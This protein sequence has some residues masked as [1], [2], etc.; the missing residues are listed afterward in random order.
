MIILYALTMFVSAL[1][2][3]MVQPM[4]AMMV[5]PLLGGS[6]A[7]WNTT[8]V[9]Y[10]VLLLVGYLYAHTTRRWLSP[11]AQL[12][13]HGVL[14]ILPLIV[15]PIGIPAGWIP[16]AATTPIPWLLALMSVA[17]G[18]PFLILSA[19]SPLLQAWFST[20][21]HRSATDPYF[22]SVASNGGS[23]LAL[24]AYPFLL[25]PR[26]SLAAQSR[27]WTA[28]YLG[29][30]ALLLACIVAVWR[31]GRQVVEV[32]HAAVP[33]RKPA[34][35]VEPLS[36]YRRCHWVLLAF[37]P[38]SLMLSVTTHLST[39][40]APIPLLWVVPLALYLLT[41]ILAFARRPLPPPWLTRRIFPYAILLLVVAFYVPATNAVKPLLVLHL[42]VYF[43]IAM[44]CH[45]ILAEDRPPAHYLTE[46]Y[47]WL[48]VGGA[49]GGIFNSLV[50]PVLFHSVAE[51]PIVVVLACALLWQ[52]GRDD[53]PRQ[54]WLDLLLPAALGGAMGVLVFVVQAQ[55][56]RTNWLVMSAVVGIPPVICFAFSRRALRFALGIGV[57]FFTY[58]QLLANPHGQVLFTERSFFGISQV[59]HNV[60]GQYHGLMH[61]RI[62]H[63]VQ[64]LDP[65]RRD[66]PLSYYSAA[67]P[68]GQFFAA[69]TDG[70]AKQ[71]VAV[72][73]LGAGALACYRQPGQHWTFY[74]IDPTVVRIARDPQYF[75]FLH[76]CAPDE[77]IVLGDAR[78]SLSR[79]PEQSY[80]LM[81]FD[82]YSG[83]AVPVHLLT[84]EALKLYVT[85]L[86]P[87]GVLA[88]HISN[89]F[90]DLRPVVANL[91]HELGLSAWMQIHP[92]TEEERERGRYASEWMV[93]ARTAADLE[94]L[95]QDTR[96]QRQDNDPDLAL[97]TDGFS[98][99]LA[100][101]K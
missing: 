80:D 84:V 1:L 60:Q 68:I 48:A 57:L 4:F 38:S 96:W 45:G 87:G 70:D 14:L 72:I 51:Y 82:A 76:D 98:N 22:L 78:L 13:F 42:I 58:A 81:I 34:E 19:T 66:E 25:Q 63:G 100:V 64:S 11:R 88:F 75:T 9:F 39:A 12:F 3:F 89:L 67:G 50:A 8:V 7:V 31:H 71:R 56:W 32:V 101:M 21:S 27:L 69:Y 85:K 94:R 86:A 91:A 36:V 99:V 59:Q 44:A 53:P 61:G 83:D 24:L 52:P 97:W 10:E 73:G 92:V 37:A 65:A 47:L 54:R 90:F 46:F 28:G 15:L 30:V 55:G 6:P 77:R 18:L 49:L 33:D 20:T 17:V 41:F 95:T 40:I 62:L 29:L 93:V 79:V 74:E 35:A 26:L 43:V 5:L 2:L 23:L 16:P